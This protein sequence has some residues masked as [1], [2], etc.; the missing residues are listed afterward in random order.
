[1]EYKSKYLQYLDEYQNFD[2]YGFVDAF[3]EIFSS[4]EI[5]ELE[6]ACQ[7][8]KCLDDFLLYYKDDNFY[9]IHLDSGTMINW[10]KHLGRDNTCNKKGFTYADL[11]EMLTALKED[12]KNHNDDNPF[13]GWKIHF[14]I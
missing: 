4:E 9:I 14:E 11:K 1:M 3:S 10:Y 8:C 5:I 2:R 12:L 6:A 13:K 7:G